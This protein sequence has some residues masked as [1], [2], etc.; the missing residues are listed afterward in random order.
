M[1][2]GGGLCEALVAGA[3]DVSRW[4]PE[5]VVALERRCALG[6]DALAGALGAWPVLGPAAPLA[7]LA[8]VA[9]AVSAAAAGAGRRGG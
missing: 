5:T 8:V 6:G 1:D 2:M 9:G 7:V 4:L 3:L